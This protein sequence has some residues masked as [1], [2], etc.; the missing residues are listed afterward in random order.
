M[1]LGLDTIRERVL[2]FLSEEY[3]KARTVDEIARTVLRR[4]SVD[5][6]ESVRVRA[7]ITR[8][9]ECGTLTRHHLRDAAMRHARFAWSYE[10]SGDPFLKVGA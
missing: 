9:E 8:F 6:L 5:R 7:V 1:S 10:P 4:Q 3:P 2:D